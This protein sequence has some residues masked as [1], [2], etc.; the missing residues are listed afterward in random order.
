[1]RLSNNT[2]QVFLD[3]VSILHILSSKLFLHHSTQFFSISVLILR[4][5]VNSIFD[6]SLAV[7]REKFHNAFILLE[8]VSSAELTKSLQKD[9][10]SEER[11][12]GK[13]CRST[14][15]SERYRKNK[16]E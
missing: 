16:Q 5:I 12:V 13:E 10:R 9:D 14:C 6:L 3:V 2:L 7:F 15:W 8:L 1:M 11:R 4:T